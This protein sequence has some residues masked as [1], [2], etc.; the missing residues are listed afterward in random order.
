MF[1]RYPLVRQADERDCGPAALATVAL[2]YRRPL[3]LEQLRH[4]AGTDRIGTSLL[5]L[6]Q[7]AETA[8]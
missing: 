6:L 4:L 1:R 7:A 2:Y 3:S 8:R 5:G